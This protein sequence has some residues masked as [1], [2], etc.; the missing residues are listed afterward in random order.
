MTPI[1]TSVSGRGAGRGERIVILGDL[2]GAGLH[3][4]RRRRLDGV[5]A[6][7]LS[8]SLDARLAAGT[9]PESDRLLAVRAAT[10]VEPAAR[11]ILARRWDELVERAGDPVRL[12]DPRVPIARERV[13]AAAELIER[14][15]DRLRASAPVAAQG[16][17]CASLLLRSGSSP[18]YR[19]RGELRDAMGRAVELLGPGQ[20]LE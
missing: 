11:A 7:L 1:D 13:L 8:Y 5:R 6:H 2:H 4:S 3:A 18:V 9:P 10:L 20:P 12:A 15:C 14:L 17:A 16:V 19:G